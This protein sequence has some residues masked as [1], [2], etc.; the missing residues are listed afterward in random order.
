MAHHDLK[1]AAAFFDASEAWLKP[2]EIRFNDRDYKVGDTLQMHEV[3]DDGSGRTGRV[4]RKW[5][6]CYVL[7]SGGGIGL[8]PGYVVLGLRE[9][10]E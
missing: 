3:A 4:G 10:P 9:V 7:H 1:L 5:A 2:F 8:L 6:I